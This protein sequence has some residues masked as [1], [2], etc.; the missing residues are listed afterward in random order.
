MKEAI[1]RIFEGR[2]AFHR[3]VIEAIDNTRHDL[4]LVD[5]DFQAWPLGSAEGERALRGA[6]MRGTRLRM[7]VVKPAWLE[8]NADRFMRLRREFSARVSVREVPET[9]RVEESILLGDR[10]HLVRRAHHESPTGRLVLS[11]PAELEFHLPRYDAIW[12]ESIECLPS[13]TLGL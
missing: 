12:D 3:A 8:R 9:L 5:Y 4:V 10:Q 6:L 7:M 1:D 2:H 13:T 11:S